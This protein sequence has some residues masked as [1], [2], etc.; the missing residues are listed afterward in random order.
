VAETA[1]ASRKDPLVP[2]PDVLTDEI[3]E[4]MQA[5]RGLFGAV[6]KGLKE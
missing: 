4:G 3:F 2:E 6:A 5:A 1:A